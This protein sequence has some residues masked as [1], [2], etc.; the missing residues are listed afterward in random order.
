MKTWIIIGEGVSYATMI[1]SFSPFENTIKGVQIVRLDDIHFIIDKNL[2]PQVFIKE[3]QVTS[4]DIYFMLGDYNLSMKVVGEQLDLLGSF[5]YNNMNAKSIAMSKIATYQALAKKGVPIIKTIPILSNIKKDFLINQLG[6]PM[7]VKPD[8]GFG[9]TGVML[10]HTEE[11]LEQV[12]NNAHESQKLFLAQKY[13]KTSKGFDIRV[14]TIGGKPIYAMK[15]QAGNPDE[16]RSNVK[17]GGSVTMVEI[18]DEILELSEKVFE[19]IGLDF[20][21]LDLLMGEEGFVIGEVNASPGMN[22]LKD[23]EELFS[24]IA[25]NV[26]KNI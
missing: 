19:S 4:P 25:K 22:F 15:R 9:G 11:E 10:I 7:V 13:I 14:V 26:E 8:N 17:L 12:L 21:G 3:E 2:P 16:F 24:T 23:S 20:A 6:L 5:A 18:T 1:K